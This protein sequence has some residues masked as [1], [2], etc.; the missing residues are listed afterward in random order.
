VTWLTELGNLALSDPE[1]AKAEDWRTFRLAALS[2]L[3][4]CESPESDRAAGES[5]DRLVTVFIRGN[6]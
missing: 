6:G 1:R 2:D 5:L 3:R 4:G